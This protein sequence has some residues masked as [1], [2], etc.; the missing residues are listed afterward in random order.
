MPAP[1]TSAAAPFAVVIL[2]WNGADDTLACLASLEAQSLPAQELVVLDN[3]S[4][5]DSVARIR[6]AYPHLR[7]VEAPRNLGFAEGANWGIE[8]T[9]AEWVMLLNNDV[10]VPPDTFALLA[11][12]ATAAPP[13][14]GMLQPLLVF[15]DRPE[16]LNSS[17]IVLLRGGS[18][19]DRDFERPT[20]LGTFEE[21]FAITAGAGLYRREML[22]RLK[23]RTGYLDRSHFMYYEDLD[24]G[25]R[26]RLAGYRA[27]VVSSAHVQHGF[28]RSAAR[29]PS[30][31]VERHCRLNR[32][33]TL[34]KNASGRMLLRY[35]LSQGFRND[36]LWLLRREG[37]LLATR[38]FLTAWVDGLRGRRTVSGYAKLR[39]VALEA[40]WLGRGAARGLDSDG[41]GR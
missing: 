7:L 2:N 27:Q 31:F 34:L 28:Q 19:I 22:E 30:G 23:L 3:G 15:A 41:P 32:C 6:A 39:R 25:W 35:F 29:R 5:D 14:T 13:D 21:P 12:A 26:A 37:A 36:L 17:G 11:A 24:L 4:E 20:E 1:P 18:A 33:R 10:I 40:D 16:L 8:R 38:A 9:E